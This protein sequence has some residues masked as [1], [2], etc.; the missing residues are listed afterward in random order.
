VT[1]VTCTNH[2][3]GHHHF[4]IMSS[5]RNAVKRITHKE[6]SQLQSRSHLGLLEKKA[7]YRL[8]S[9]NYKHKQSAMKVLR[10]KVAN[11]NPDEYYMQMNSSRVDGQS[12]RHVKTEEQR[13]KE[14]GYGDDAVRIM[15]D[16][17]LQYVRMQRVMDDRKIERLQSS[18]HY[19]TKDDDDDKSKKKRKHTLFVEGN[20]EEFDV[21]QHFDTVPE[22]MDRAFH[23]PR[24]KVLEKEARKTFGANRTTLDDSED[25]TKQPTEKQLKK[26]KKAQRYLERRVAK[27]RSAAYTEMEMRNERVQKLKAAEEALIV[28]KQCGMKGRRRKIADG[29]G[30]KPAQYKWRR[31]RAK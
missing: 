14:Q 5:L 22:F 29:D 16:Q 27:S 9:T 15:K 13:R 26:Q 23:R 6:R 10:T 19:L 12:G 18:L 3:D 4:A 11:R 24:I 31:K 25:E 21:V 7:D 17:D 30:E 20:L 1:E 2:T 28:E 8:R